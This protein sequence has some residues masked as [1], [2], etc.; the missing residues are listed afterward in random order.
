MCDE[1]GEGGR[2]GKGGDSEKWYNEER[3]D[4][5]K[6]K[7]NLV[8]SNQRGISIRRANEGKQRHRNEDLNDITVPAEYFLTKNGNRRAEWSREPPPCKTC[9][10]EHIM[11]VAMLYERTE[12]V[13]WV[14]AHV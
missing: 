3:E 4:A 12:Y 10:D 13:V 11:Q 2:G 9:P 8:K 1:E 6:K 5:L 14:N 7:K